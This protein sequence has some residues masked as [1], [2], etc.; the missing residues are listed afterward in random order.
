MEHPHDPW[1]SEEAGEKEREK[2]VIVEL[3][4][5]FGYKFPKA[6]RMAQKVVRFHEM[7][8]KE[9]EDSNLFFWDLDYCVFFL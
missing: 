1:R 9:D 5:R 2:D 7:L 3:V 8:L 6:K 4:E